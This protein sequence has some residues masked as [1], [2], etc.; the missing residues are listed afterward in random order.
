MSVLLELLLAVS[1]VCTRL[2]S[3]TLQSRLY[4]SFLVPPLVHIPTDAPLSM[5]DSFEL[6]LD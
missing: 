3:Y 4:F 2:P 1:L 5:I 6:K